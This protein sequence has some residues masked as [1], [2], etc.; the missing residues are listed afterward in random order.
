LEFDGTP[1]S[2][3]PK[4][5]TK[6]A[7]TY[8]IDYTDALGYTF[9]HWETTPGI[10]VADP[11]AWSATATVTGTGT[12][13]A[14][15][16]VIFV[17]GFSTIT[18]ELVMGSV[19]GATTFDG[20]I[21]NPSLSAY[22]DSQCLNRVVEIDWGPKPLGSMKNVI[23]YLRNEGKTVIT[24]IRQMAF[25]T[26]FPSLP[27]QHKLVIFPPPPAGIKGNVTNRNVRTITEEAEE[28]VGVEEFV[29]WLGSL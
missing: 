28:A 27:V 24:P 20:W 6:T 1:Y 7:R 25:Y 12:L 9:D 8:A 2:S 23:L 10:T 19:S 3:L 14:I 5:L 4:D 29:M 17:H 15:Y 26:S 21:K 16:K 18:T 22:W 13:R 11:N